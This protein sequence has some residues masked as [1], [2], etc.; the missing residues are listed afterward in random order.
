MIAFLLLA[1]A[2]LVLGSAHLP[3][4]HGWIAVVFAALAIVAY[5]AGGHLSLHL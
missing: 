5:F 1:V 3:T 4:P 2:V